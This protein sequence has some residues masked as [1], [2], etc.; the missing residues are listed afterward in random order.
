MNNKSMYIIFST[1][2]VLVRSKPRLCLNLNVHASIYGY[3]QLV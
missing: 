3:I 2:G 1:C